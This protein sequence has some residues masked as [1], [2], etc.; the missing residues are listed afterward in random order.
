LRYENFGVSSHTV[1]AYFGILEDTL[2]ER[3]LPAHRKRSKRRV[4]GAP[5]FYFADVG[6]VNRLA[7]RAKIQPGSELQGKAFENWVYHELV[8]YN[9]HANA[10]AV[11]SYWRLPSGIEVD[12]IVNDM[13]LAIET[14]SSARI[15]SDHLKGLRH[16][17]RDHSEVRRRLAVSLESKARRTEDG[18]EILPATTFVEAL[19]QGDFF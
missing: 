6:I 8:A 9:A 5:K 2:L 12:F 11:I 15:T 7:R 16:F 19:S 17:A 14:K 18:I 4:I 13:Q 10:D 3:S 1:K